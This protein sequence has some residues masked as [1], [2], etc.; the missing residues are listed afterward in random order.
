QDAE[1]LLVHADGVLD[2]QRL[3][4]TGA[5]M[6]VEILDQAE[7]IAA[8]LQ[9]VG[10]VAEAV[11]AG[12]EGILAPLLRRRVAV[13]YNHL[14][15]GDAIEDGTLAAVVLVTKVVEHEAFAGV[16][17]DDE[18]PLLPFHAVAIDFEAGPLRLVDLKRLDV[19]ARLGDPVGGI[20][21]LLR[22]QR[23]V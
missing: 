17:T 18:A 1:I 2:R 8:Q 13:G 22:R 14:G 7:A 5:E 10:A 16:E 12:V 21:S 4:A 3:A 6:A 11:L 19:I 20:V 23:P 9:A 15:Q